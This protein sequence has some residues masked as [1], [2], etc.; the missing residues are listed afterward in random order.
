MTDTEKN[1]ETK[2]AAKRKTASKAKAKPKAEP[3]AKPKAKAKI[4]VKAEPK[5]E[6]TKK[7]N[8]A[9]ATPYLEKDS[10]TEPSHAEPPKR[11][12][13]T[14]LGFLFVLVVLV[15]TTIY[16]FNDERSNLPAQ[17]DVQENNVN[18]EAASVAMVQADTVDSNTDAQSVHTTDQ[19][20][21]PTYEKTHEQ[22]SVQT[23]ERATNYNEMMQQRRQAYEKEM[24]SRQ[25]QYKATMEAYQQERAKIAE[26]RKN[27][28]LRSRQNQLETRNKVQE[29]QRQISDLHE[30]MRQLMRESHAQ[31][32]P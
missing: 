3:K 27:V 7:A 1:T 14:S 21:P 20:I 19:Q 24:Q 26:A 2:A 28:F 8:T 29:I 10:K 15:L 32:R 5:A 31:R 4:K 12:S 23:Q 17:G 22:D 13:L 25:Q 30:K 9:D 16:K 18:A 6:A 11:K